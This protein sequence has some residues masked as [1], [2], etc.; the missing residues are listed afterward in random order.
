MVIRRIG[1]LS[2]AKL[3][4]ALYAVAGLLLGV[5]FSLVSLAGGFAAAAFAADPSRRTA[6]IPFAGVGA[7]A[8]VIFPILYAAL[9]FVGA[10]IGTWLYNAAAAVLGGIQI[11][12]E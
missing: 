11:D 6:I 3:A 5:I 1:P 4:A 12:L 9:G 10:L 8:I 7:L 2:C